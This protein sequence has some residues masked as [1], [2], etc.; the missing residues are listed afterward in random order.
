M[1]ET[2]LASA[3][4][5]TLLQELETTLTLRV[6]TCV[7]CDNFDSPNYH[8]LFYRQQVPAHIIV[9]GCDSFSTLIPF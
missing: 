9:A 2:I 7:E 4:L 1:Q 8:C 5:R 6:R 3:Y